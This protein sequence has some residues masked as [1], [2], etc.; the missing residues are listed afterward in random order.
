MKKIK[1]YSTTIKY[2]KVMDNLPS[3]IKPLGLGDFQ[4][5]SHWYDEK[6]GEN[7]S[8]LNKFYAEFTGLYWILK[9]QLKEF[10]DND[11]I[12]NCHNRV[13]WLN[14]FSKKKVKFTKSS[15][16]NKLLK[17][18]DDI[19]FS[20]D[21]IQVQPIT[22]KKKNL[23]IDFEEVHK[24]DALKISLELLDKNIAID[25]EKHLKGHEIFPHNMF[26]TKKIFF[27]EY[28]ETIFP[29]LDKCF[30]YCQ[31]KNLCNG[32]NARLPAFLA[33]RFTS[34]WFSK[35]KNRAVLSYARLGK[36]HLSNK[37]NYFINSIKLPFTY[38]QYPTIHDY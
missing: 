27:E 5:P 32:Y 21:A 13:L 36:F 31:E 19:L 14:N 30:K 7:I 24:C 6:N 9:N 1:I 28:C 16:Y 18:S 35:F 23:F 20:N 10:E 2:Y 12:G 37:V 29:W 17:P 22:F 26:I 33:E 11:L 38:C 15:L 3:F 34:Y 4:Y 8:H 25:F